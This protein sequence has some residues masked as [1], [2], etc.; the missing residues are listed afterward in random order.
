MAVNR[1]FHILG[2][3]LVVIVMIVI[4]AVFLNL[5]KK[6]V[7]TP[8]NGGGALVEV[9]EAKIADRRV[10][11]EGAGTVAPRYEVTVMPQVNGRVNWV[12][13]KLVAGGEFREGEEF[14]RIEAAD[15]ELAVQQAEAQVA[16]AEFQ[17]DVA[18]ANATIARG[19]WDLIVSTRKNS[20]SGST[21]SQEPNPL[22]LHQPQLRQAE[23]DLALAHAAL[24]TAQLNLD[25]THLYAPFDCRVR[26]Q[27][28][29]PG[30]VVGPANAVA[31]LY[32]TDLVEIEVGLPIA[33][34]EWIHVPGD[35]ALV[36]LD[37]GQKKFTWKGISHRARGV[38]DEIGCLERLVV[39]LENPSHQMDD[40]APELSIGSPVTV[41]IQ[42]RMLKNIIPIP[43]SSI[44]ENSMVW[45]MTAENT[46]EIRP[47]TIHRMTP[48][49][50]LIAD[51]LAQGEKVILTPLSG[52]APG[53]RLRTI[54]PK[55]R[56]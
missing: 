44:R 31:V 51:G 39:R 5:R 32:A 8:R 26:R 18:R 40:H 12:S 13:P 6:P 46:L 16:Q 42:G 47:V 43:R 48:T 7:I 11:I 41:Q 37:T 20:G 15:Y 10:V 56:S 52:A 50:A 19:E 34:L 38:V 27:S 4:M 54:S 25:R 28:I 30:Q 33:D 2:P 35:T 17:L 29:A 1:R 3:L 49:E 22:V 36:T 24:S 9:I 53:M 23:A 45:I 55:E 21:G 14:L